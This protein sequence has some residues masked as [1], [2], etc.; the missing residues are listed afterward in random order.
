M[1]R[2][3]GGGSPSPVADLAEARDA[4]RLRDHRERVDEVV[5][6]NKRALAR[7]F[8]SGLIYSRQ[9]AR[10]GRDLLLAHQHLLKLGDLLARLDDLHG[11]GR[12]GS[13]EDTEAVYAEA[14]KL[15]A[16]TAELSARSDGLVARGL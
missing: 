8:Q 16:R 1:A 7:L 4:R 2:R 6:A 5:E 10:L 13:D 9:G 14:H 11:R 15:L 12:R 3:A